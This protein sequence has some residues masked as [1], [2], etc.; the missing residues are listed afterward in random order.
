MDYTQGISPPQWSKLYEYFESI[1]RIH[2]RNEDK[3][4]R[5]MEAVFWILRSGAQ[6]R[7]LPK[8]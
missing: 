1:P 8:E 5:F 6:W 2:T 7:M 3:A 4:K